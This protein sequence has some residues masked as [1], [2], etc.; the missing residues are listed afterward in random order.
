MLQVSGGGASRSWM[1]E[2]KRS[3]AGTGGARR[4]G[5]EHAGAESSPLRANAGGALARRRLAGS[6]ALEVGSGFPVPGA[7]NGRGSDSYRFRGSVCGGGRRAGQGGSHR[8]DPR[9][10]SAD[11]ERRKLPARC[12]AGETVVRVEMESAQA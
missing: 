4:C 10:G 12:R 6:G 11:L 2:R 5:T 9:H 3:S 8:R 7:T 1:L